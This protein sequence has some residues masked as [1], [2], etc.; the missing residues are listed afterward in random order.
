MFY[1]RIYGLTVTSDIE[2]PEA[3]QIEPMNDT[4]VNILQEK[5]N[6]I[7]IKE[8][9][10]Y[11]KDLIN[12]HG[13]YRSYNDNKEAYLWLEDTGFFSMKYGTDIRYKLEDNANI[14]FVRQ[15]LLVHCLNIILMQQ[16]VICIHGSGLSNGDG[17]LI[18]SGQSG[19]GKSTLSTALLDMGLGYVADDVNATK[20]VDGNVMIEPAYPQ[21]KLCK[22]AMLNFGYS[23]NEHEIIP[24]LDKEK[25]SLIVT[26]NYRKESIQLDTIVIIEP[27]NV[28]YVELKLI[29][30]SKKVK[31]IVDNVFAREEYD[32]V[33]FGPAEVTKCMLIANAVD[34]YVM[35]RPFGRDTVA[36]QVHLLAGYG[37]IDK[38]LLDD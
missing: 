31:Y 38:H 24:S 8:L 12:Q 17:G 3:Y 14:V 30:G 25:Y 26:E 6:S 34:V 37:I 23:E 15:V 2:I 18:I 13:G 1:Y 22:D 33:G 9:T 27:D 21:R 10:Q 16:S 29:T 28:G 5:G 11:E 19:A 35:K 4:Q 36:E 32:K 7:G 20:L